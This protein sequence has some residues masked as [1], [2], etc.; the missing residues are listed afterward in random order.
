MYV[1][2]GYFTSL[3][4]TNMDVHFSEPED[5]DVEDPPLKKTKGKAPAA[6][7]IGAPPPSMSKSSTFQRRTK[8]PK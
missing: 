1:S 7:Y 2:R 6:G 4:F 8:A 5:S 3:H